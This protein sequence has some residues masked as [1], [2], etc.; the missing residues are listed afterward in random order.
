MK[1]IL[2]WVKNYLSKKYR[3]YNSAGHPDI[4]NPAPVRMDMDILRIDSIQYTKIYG[5]VPGKRWLTITILT[6]KG[7]STY[8]VSSKLF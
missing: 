1:C 4:C 8:M 2:F 6:P 5:R 3:K 7:S